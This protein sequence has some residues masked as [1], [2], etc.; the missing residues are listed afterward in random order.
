MNAYASPNDQNDRFG[1][2]LQ[3]LFDSIEVEAREAVA[4]IDRV[5]V[6]EVRRE[7]AGASRVLA[8]HLV[9]F[10]DRLHPLDNMDDSDGKRGL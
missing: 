7:A 2:R 5:I 4:Y 6:P 1:P 3:A 9:R 8:G 10:A